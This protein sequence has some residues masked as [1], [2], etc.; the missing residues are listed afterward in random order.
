MVTA[1]SLAFRFVDAAPALSLTMPGNITDGYADGLKK[2]ADAFLK[3]I[4]VLKNQN[5]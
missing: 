2:A 3:A 1:A 5:T 4:A